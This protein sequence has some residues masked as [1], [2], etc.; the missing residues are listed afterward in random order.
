MR[1]SEYLGELKENL[2][3]KL[4]PEITKDILADYESFFVSGRE[5]G[6]TDDEISGELG[7]PAFLAKS[8]LEEQAEIETGRS[9]KHLANPGRRLGAYFIDT[10][11][12]VLPAFIVT[13]IIG[14]T[15][16]SYFLLIMYPSPLSG[17]FV[18]SSY[19]T[20]QEF[21]TIESIPYSPD[22]AETGRKI[23]RED[24]RKPSPVS[25][26]AALFTLA[27]YLLYSLTATLIFQGQTVG[28]KL[29]RIKVRRSNTGPLTKGGI[30]SRELLGKILINS[31]PVIPLISIFMILFTKEH[32]ALHDMLADTIVADV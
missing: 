28:K 26:A 6:K 17:V 5:D 21:I 24:T 8:L 30:L 19:A 18:Y 29:M 1:Q 31:I 22:N 13:C 4:A 15:L 20:Y 11:I 10:V 25:I 2:E 9:D 32:Q 3:G 16:L 23:V 27:F 14:S 7:S 12:A